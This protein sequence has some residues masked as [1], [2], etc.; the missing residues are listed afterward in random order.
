MCDLLVKLCISE[1][2]NGIKQHVGLIKIYTELLLS[3]KHVPWLIGAS[4]C[5][6]ICYHLTKCVTEALDVPPEHSRTPPKAIGFYV[7]RL[8]QIVSVAKLQADNDSIGDLATRLRLLEVSDHPLSMELAGVDIWLMVR[9]D[10]DSKEQGTPCLGRI[11][12]IC[13]ILEKDV[14]LP[15][16]RISQ[17]LRLL[18]DSTSLITK[19]MFHTIGN[20]NLFDH[21]INAFCCGVSRLDSFD[22]ENNILQIAIGRNSYKQLFCKDVLRLLMEKWPDEFGVYLEVFDEPEFLNIDD[23]AQDNRQIDTVSAFVNHCFLGAASRQTDSTKLKDLVVSIHPCN[24]ASAIL[25]SFSSAKLAP[26]LNLITP[27]ELAKVLNHLRLILEQNIC[28][29]CVVIS[30]CIFLSYMSKISLEDVV[31][32]RLRSAIERV[33]EIALQSRRKI[34]RLFGLA[35]LSSFVRNVDDPRLVAQF[36][37]PVKNELTEMLQVNIRENRWG[38]VINTLDE[39]HINYVEALQNA[40]FKPEYT[41][42]SGSSTKTALSQV[43]KECSVRALCELVFTLEKKKILSREDRALLN[44]CAEKLKVLANQ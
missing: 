7:K 1:S 29:D 9:N 26:H 39:V 19:H 3:I 42:A 16:H 31:D 8:L 30:V 11:I 18:L 20:R 12:L 36:T 17:F 44:V 2:R 37:K 43:K 27:F 15:S 13:D 10:L 21:S 34:G 6:D 25:F 41:N 40:Y 35:A 38:E 28:N 32:I 24:A 5:K 33:T 22:L 4:Q 14:E 23:L